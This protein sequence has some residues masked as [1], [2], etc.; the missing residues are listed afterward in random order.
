MA[1]SVAE[2]SRAARAV[3]IVAHLDGAAHAV[4]RLPLGVERLGDEAIRGCG[5]PSDPAVCGG[6]AVDQVS[7]GDRGGGVDAELGVDR[8]VEAPEQLARGGVQTRE[9]AREVERVLPR[10]LTVSATAEA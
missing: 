7:G 5:D 3:E 4:G 9:A 8:L 2:Q 1:N 6:G 10:P